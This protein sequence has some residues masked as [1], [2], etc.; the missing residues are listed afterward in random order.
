MMQRAARLA[1]ITRM[2]RHPPNDAPKMLDVRMVADVFRQ[3]EKA[4]ELRKR[5]APLLCHESALEHQ[6]RRCVVDVD[7][8][9]ETGGELPGTPRGLEEP[10]I[11]IATVRFLKAKNSLNSI[12]GVVWIAFGEEVALP[13]QSSRATDT[14]PI[15]GAWWRRAE[16]ARVVVAQAPRVVWIRVAR[17]ADYGNRSRDHGCKDEEAAL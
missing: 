12:P 9:H 11:L 2:N 5:D 17:K 6:S 10:G 4:A 3:A 16:Q 7:A 15:R 13:L 1:V 8:C 14:L